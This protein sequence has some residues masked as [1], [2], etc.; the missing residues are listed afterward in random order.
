MTFE[1]GDD[2]DIGDDSLTVD[3]GLV[4]EDA[5]GE[6][7]DFDGVLV[8]WTQAGTDGLLSF[9]AG[10]DADTGDIVPVDQSLIDDVVQVAAD[11]L[12]E[13]IKEA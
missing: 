2:Y 9:G 5:E 8:V 4:I 12:D 1:E 13:V 6:T 11:K 3:V 10:F 7:F